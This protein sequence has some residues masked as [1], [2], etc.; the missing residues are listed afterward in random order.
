MANDNFTT[1]ILDLL[2]PLGG[3]KARKMFSGVGIYKDGIFFALIADNI[4]Y[5]KVDQEMQAVYKAIGS[6]PFTYTRKG[7]LVALSYWKLPVDILENQEKLAQYVKAAVQAAQRA[8][9]N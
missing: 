7:K 5:F 3:I 9:K 2:L 1:Y 6:K 8:K 4:L